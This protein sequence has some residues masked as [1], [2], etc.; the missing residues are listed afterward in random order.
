MTFLQKHKALENEV[1]ANLRSIKDMPK[2]CL[3]HV[4][5]VEEE[6]DEGH[7][8]FNEYKLHKINKDGTCSLENSI[9]GELEGNRNLSEIEVSW[10][11]TVWEQYVSL[12]AEE[13]PTKPEIKP[14]QKET[15]ML[16]YSTDRFDENSP[17]DDI[18]RDTG[19]RKVDDPARRFTLENF[20]LA[21]NDQR[22][23]DD[24]CWIRLIEIEV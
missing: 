18:L 9:T 4:V 15:F 8:V 22:I 14:K 21:F 13:N 17:T 10:L 6:N 24:N 11:I 23:S 19:N 12:M 3:P 2:G 1:V 20:A 16:V 5:F 7:P